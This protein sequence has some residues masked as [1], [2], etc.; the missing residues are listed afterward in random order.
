M[1][2]A[3]ELGRKISKN[4]FA[5]EELEIHTALLNAQRDFERLLAD[6][7]LQQRAEEIFISTVQVTAEDSGRLVGTGQVTYRLL[8]PR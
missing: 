6:A 8:E 7:H 4:V 5:K 1:F 2:E 3:A